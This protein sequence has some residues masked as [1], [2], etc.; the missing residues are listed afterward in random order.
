MKTI[1]PFLLFASVAFAAEVPAPRI[2]KLDPALDALIASDVKIEKVG[3]GYSWS[4]GPV[5]FK[6]RFIFSDVPT[7][8]A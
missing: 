4:E 8:T 6:D 2:E 3:T 7:N 5:W 1:A